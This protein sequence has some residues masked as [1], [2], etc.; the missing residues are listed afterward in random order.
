MTPGTSTVRLLL[1]NWLRRNRRNIEMD[2]YSIAVIAHVVAGSIAL[3]LFWTTHIAFLGIG[4]R[5]AVP[6]LDP[7][8]L[9]L[10]AFTAPIGVAIAAGWWLNRKYGKPAAPA[11]ARKD[12]ATVDQLEPVGR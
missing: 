8:S 2:S 3:I 5:K 7:G 1:A 12:R 10:L 9:Q 11:L 4:L 6:A